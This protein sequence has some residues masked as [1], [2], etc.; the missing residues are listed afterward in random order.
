MK[1]NC[2]MSICL[3]LIS[4]SMLLKTSIVSA[5]DNVVANSDVLPVTF[6]GSGN[7]TWWPHAIYFKAELYVNN[8][9]VGRCDNASYPISGRS[10]YYGYTSTCWTLAQSITHNGRTYELY[11]NGVRQ[12]AGISF[13]HG[14]YAPSG[15]NMYLF[16]TEGLSTISGATVIWEGTGKAGDYTLSYQ[17]MLV[18]YTYR[19][20]LPSTTTHYAPKVDGTTPNPPH[21]S[22]DT[23]SFISGPVEV[24]DAKLGEVLPDAP[25]NLITGGYTNNPLSYAGTGTTSTHNQYTVQLRTIVDNDNIM[26]G[27]TFVRTGTVDLT[28]KITDYNNDSTTFTVRYTVTDPGSNDINIYFPGLEKTPYDGRWMSTDPSADANRQ[29]GLDVQASS[30]IN[31]NYDL[32][33]F[34][35]GN[36]E[37]TDEVDKIST[38]TDPV[39]NGVI[40]GWSIADSTTAGV[41]ATSQAFLLNDPDTAFSAMSN[42]KLMYFDS[43]KPTITE[44]ETTD[45]WATITTDAQDDAS[46]IGGLGIHDTG[47]VFFKFVPKGNTTGITT[48]TDGSDWISID[49]YATTFADLSDGEYDLYV[50]AK[51]NATNRSEA[52]KANKDAPIKVGEDTA[53]ITV[54]KEV[55]GT[56]GDSND[57]FLINLHEGSDLLTSVALK[58]GNASKAITLDMSSDPSKTINV[59]ELIPMDYDSD[60][61]LSV[62]DNKDSSETPITGKAITVSLGDDITIVVKNTFAPTGFFKAKDFVKNIFKQ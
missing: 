4:L 37:Q 22:S 21:H 38:D 39:T 19:A 5:E 45:D 53:S 24:V 61:T 10:G 31:G 46:G 44:V 12:S 2:K 25:Q 59:S 1:K 30:T 52:I 60:F 62:I 9:S 11:R 47:G 48:P 16:I 57:V 14:G 33:T 43:T 58:D 15:D 29:G 13:A 42:E 26:D 28:W 40:S 32:S 7:L 23:N 20:P 55:V 49:N 41:P 35:S 56:K 54:K 17:R 18:T 34:I 6:V 3:I 36:K 51:D 50:Y 8:S 27:N